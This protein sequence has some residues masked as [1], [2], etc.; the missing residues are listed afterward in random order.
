MSDEM[1]FKKGS[2]SFRVGRK[3]VAVILSC[4]NKPHKVIRNVAMVDIDSELE[5]VSREL[6]CYRNGPAKWENF[7]KNKLPRALNRRAEKDRK[8]SYEQIKSAMA[9]IAWSLERHKIKD[10]YGESGG[11]D[12]ADEIWKAWQG[13]RS[14]ISVAWRVTETQA[15]ERVKQRKV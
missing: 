5:N 8:M 7:V 1:L 13:I 12:V 3:S 11:K 2:I 6:C 15:L 9:D 10:V 14:V 4:Y